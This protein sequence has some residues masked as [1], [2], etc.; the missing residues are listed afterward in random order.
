MDNEHLEKALKNVLNEDG[1][2]KQ[3]T[4]DRL[5]LK[6]YNEWLIG[7]D[8]LVA[9]CQH[10]GLK[11][12]EAM[13]AFDSKTRALDAELPEGLGLPDEV[14]ILIVQNAAKQLHLKILSGILF[15]IQLGID[16]GREEYALKI[17]QVAKKG[18]KG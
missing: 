1:S 18:A 12:A 5:Q 8:R 15:G 6:G 2:L 7:Q 3:E 4:Y 16:I 10:L 9:F 11:T 17:N 14:K 13:E